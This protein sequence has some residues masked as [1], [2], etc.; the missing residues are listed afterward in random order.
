M[1]ENARNITKPI[2]LWAAWLIGLTTVVGMF[3]G[4]AA[5]FSGWERSALV[6]A[7]IAYVPALFSAMFLLQTKFRAELQEDS[8]YSEMVI[9]RKTEAVMPVSRLDIFETKMEAQLREIALQIQVGAVP[10]L[11]RSEGDVDV[12]EWNAW[13]IAINTRHPNYKLIKET[14]ESKGIPVSIAFGTEN[15]PSKW[16]VAI[17]ENMPRSLASQLLVAVSEFDFDGFVLW[18]PVRDV[19]ETEDVYIGSYGQ[20]DYVEFTSGF[21][22]LV[23]DEFSF[24]EYVLKNQYKKRH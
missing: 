24:S 7:A 11:S 2:Q 9:N 19:G 12:N 4:A 15:T 14:L 5:H 17:N 10:A 8:Y 20:S 6:V 23:T 3:L 16:I 13:K 1:K 18:T 21:A 22:D